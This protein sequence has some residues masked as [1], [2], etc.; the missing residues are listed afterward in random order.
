MSPR[1][2]LHP[3]QF[4]LRFEIDAIERAKVLHDLL[5]QVM[6]RAPSVLCIRTWTADAR[7]QAEDWARRELL[8]ASDNLI[9]R[10]RTPAL[11]HYAFGKRG[12][13]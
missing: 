3:T 1:A 10:M 7:E 6:K 4:P 2:R 13:L 5:G 8:Y 11:L 12:V 9:P